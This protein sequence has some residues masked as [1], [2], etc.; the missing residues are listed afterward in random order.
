MFVTNTFIFGILV[1]LRFRYK[2]T[3]V[4]FV[5]AVTG[6]LYFIKVMFGNKT[7]IGKKCLVHRAHLVDS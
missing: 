7:T 6:S 4:Q 1:K 3:D 5:E 2:V